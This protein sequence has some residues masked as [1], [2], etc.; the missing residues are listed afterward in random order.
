MD[1]DNRLIKERISKVHELHGL[2]V[3]PYPYRF[4]VD[5]YAKDIL[6]KHYGLKE[7]EST[8][9]NVKVAGR[10]MT[11][12]LMGNATF[13]HVQDS[14][15]QVQV[16]LSKDKLENYD[17][18]K[19]KLV[20]LGDI[21]GVQGN[22]FKTKRGE[23]SI[24]VKKLELLSKAIR[25]LPDKFHGLSDTEIRYRQ[26]YVDL[27]VNP[28]VR[29]VFE[30]RAKILN[31]VREFLGQRGFIEAEIPIIQPIYGGAN[32][33][34][35]KTHIN[36]WGQDMYL[37]ISPEL[38][39]KRLIVGGFSKVYS[40]G[41]SF[42]NEGVDKTHNPE[43]TTMECY[44]AYAD[45][46]DMMKLTE[47]LFEYVCKSVIGTTKIKY[48]GL[49]INFKKPWGRMTMHDAIREYASID[50]ER[51]S[52]KDLMTFVSR[53]KIELK[54]D[55]NRGFA[56]NAIF[57]HFCESKLVQPTFI[58]NHPK[59][60]TPL[61][62]ALRGHPDLI[63]RFEPFVNGWEVANAYSELNDPLLQKRLLEE[64]AAKGRGGDEMAHQMD[65]D[66]VRAL[67]HGMPPTGGLGIGIDRMVMLLTDSA[68]IRD[69]ILFPTMRHEVKD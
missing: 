35:F 24:H 55:F 45:Y 52:D 19:S 6:E 28:E 22:V 58:T 41:K 48:Q 11:L 68:T 63:E 67:E 44:Q 43:F 10:I 49:E 40:L 12:R 26:R 18:I 25:S 51:M 4:D 56:I 16:Y 47:D 5:T 23:I 36:A 13:S 9:H 14:T 50:A 20:E 17:M 39:L 21:I 46:N 42:R 62:K 64:Q 3:N 57:E 66:F 32:A 61:C 15:G 38:Y 27:I 34:P 65:E 54:G 69:V 59:E 7:G 60:T 31:A 53:N 30:T 1:E 33:K 8:K 29:K 2:G 37:S